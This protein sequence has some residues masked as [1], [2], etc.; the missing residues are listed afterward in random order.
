MVFIVSLHFCQKLLGWI[1]AILPHPTLTDPP[2]PLLLLVK[3]SAT[4][5][6][7]RVEWGLKLV[8]IWGLLKIKR[9]YN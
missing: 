7:A 3:S 1:T 8:K 6:W 5:G 4:W 2:F 9:V